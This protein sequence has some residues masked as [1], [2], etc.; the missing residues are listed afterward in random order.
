MAEQEEFVRKICDKQSLDALCLLR[1]VN[2][3]KSKIVEG[4]LI[5][6]YEKKRLAIDF[7]KYLEL[8]KDIDQ[9]RN[10]SF[11]RKKGCFDLDEISD[12]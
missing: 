6:Y 11:Q 4:R 3:E 7:E 8:V 1:S 5:S 9:E 10:I 2:K 12:F